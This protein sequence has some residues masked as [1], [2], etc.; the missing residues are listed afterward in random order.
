[1]AEASE[2]VHKAILALSNTSTLADAREKVLETLSDTDLIKVVSDTW[3]GTLSRNSRNAVA[4]L[5]FDLAAKEKTFP[6][7]Q[8]VRQEPETRGGFVDGETDVG[9]AQRRAG[10][11][12]RSI[13]TKPSQC[14]LEHK[15]RF[16]HAEK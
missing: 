16:C 1:M 5:V 11:T 8:R 12:S 10:P 2:G 6:L 13:S 14:L 4:L 15:P 7:P 3:R 9:T